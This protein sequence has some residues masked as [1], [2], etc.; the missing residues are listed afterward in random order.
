MAGLG[1]KTYDELVESRKRCRICMETDPGEIHNGD[2]FDFDP[3][4]VS[5]WSQ[6]LGHPNPILLI[7][8]Q[9]FS[10]IGYFCRNQGT[11]EPDNETNENLR[12]LLTEAE[13]KVEKGPARDE[14]ARVFLTNS[15][16]CLKAG[17]M[18]APIKH[19]WVDAC[20]QNHLLPLIN[21]L[22]A[23]IVIGMGVNG[24]RAVRK[25][26]QLTHTPPQIKRAA[27]GSWD[28]PTGTRIF[29]VVHCSNLGIGNRPWPQ[30]LADW[31]RIGDAV[32]ELRP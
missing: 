19:R 24:W 4:V 7:V 5:Y 12:K 16:L 11:D 20:A 3:P 9:D 32:R 25:V 6:W 10:D 22:N 2:E 17:R 28:T 29:P 27:G 15:I 14:G 1:M 23:P 13:V 8:G 21:Y 18:N 26:F 31:R 30:Q